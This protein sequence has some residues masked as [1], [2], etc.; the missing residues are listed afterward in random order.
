M[1]QISKCGVSPT[2]GDG[3]NYVKH[4]PDVELPS[5]DFFEE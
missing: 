3:E 5:L 4:Y 1:L 2:A